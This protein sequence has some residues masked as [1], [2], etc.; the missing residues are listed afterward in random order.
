MRNIRK[1]I[2]KTYALHVSDSE[3]RSLRM[4]VKI[5]E[6]ILRTRRSCG[7]R[8][9]RLMRCWE[10]YSRSL[11]RRERAR[12]GRLTSVKLMMTRVAGKLWREHERDIE[13]LDL[14]VASHGEDMKR[15]LHC[16]DA[17]TV[18]MDDVYTDPRPVSKSEK[19]KK[20]E[21]SWALDSFISEL[22]TVV[23]Y[24][25]CPG[26]YNI[27]VVDLLAFR[28]DKMR[29]NERTGLEM[30]VRYKLEDTMEILFDMPPPN[31]EAVKSRLFG[32]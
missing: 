27:N 16:L 11:A 18:Y 23:S 24:R 8:R 19:R 12:R 25:R 21:W 30:A 20:R 5:C 29:L 2:L 32:F 3:S 13:N 9:A 26:Y 6:E 28:L 31:P 17:A 10:R 15:A 1:T 7:L 4:K 22:R 14:L